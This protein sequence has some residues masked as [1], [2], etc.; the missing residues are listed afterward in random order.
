[1]KAET[2]SFG[3]LKLQ[4]ALSTWL[5]LAPAI[6]LRVSGTDF[7]YGA[8]ALLVVHA[9][10]GCQQ[11]FQALFLSWL[12]ASLNPALF[13]L[14]GDVEL[15]RVLILVVA[16]IRT[17]VESRSH[18]MSAMP[19]RVTIPL[20]VFLVICFANSIFV[21]PLPTLSLLKTLLF[22]LT[23]LS[24]LGMW[25]RVDLLREGIDA[26]LLAAL[27]L[28]VLASVPLIFFGMG[29]EINDRGF[30]GIL[31]HPQH[32]G[33]MVALLATWQLGVILTKRLFSVWRILLL[34]LFVTV[35]YISEARTGMLAFTLGTLAAGVISLFSH[36]SELRRVLA[37][38]PRIFR[39]VAGGMMIILAIV[40]FQGL[41]QGL[42]NAVFKGDADST[43]AENF[44]GSRG[45][46]I[47][48]A[49]N[50]FVEHPLF[51]SGFAMPTFLE[52]LEV[53]YDPLFGIPVSA[54]V[55][56]G[57]LP[58]AVLEELGIV[59]ALS[60][61]WLIY[62]LV[63]QVV[64]HGAYHMIGLMI[65]A[66]TINLGESVLFSPSGFGLLVWLIIGM[67][68]APVAQRRIETVE[69]RPW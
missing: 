63:R 16:A 10:R 46:L 5:L 1:M 36:R 48:R 68:V 24:V 58:A 50:N 3:G 26:W 25:V 11:A 42:E 52:L 43:L 14:M 59:G 38:M 69:S 54:S 34:G 8:F 61:L 22:G 31:N 44:S 65:C 57:V 20:L 67:T 28:V 64:R 33:I 9:A 13:P 66:L 18:L 37:D 55:E 35:L 60:F 47:E 49:L 40:F 62:A 19:R 56:K 53:R 17:T 12:F 30:Q 15:I 2:A 21:S 4:F 27:T 51:G 29:Y 39:A 41:L 7:T 32:F 23:S 45:M 6:V